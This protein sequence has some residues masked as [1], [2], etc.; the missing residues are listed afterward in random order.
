MKIFASFSVSVLL[1]FLPIIS[2]SQITFDLKPVELSELPGIQSF[3]YAQ[4]DGK[5]LIL[6]GRTDGLHKRRPFEAFLPSGNNGRIYVVDIESKEVWSK[7]LFELPVTLQEQLQSTNMEF[8]QKGDE[9][10]II[11]GYAFSNTAGDHITFPFLAV[12]DVPGVISDIISDNSI[13]DNFKQLRDER[14]A[15]TGGNLEV[16]DDRFYLVGGQRFDGAYN[17]MGP[18]HGPGFSQEY[19]NAIRSFTVEENGSQL[20]IK[21]YESLYDETNL[22]RRDYNL[23]PQIY[24]DG[25]Q[26]FTIFSGVFQHE[27]DLPF[28]NTV[29]ITSNGYAVNNDFSQYLSHYHSAHVP[30]FSE[31]ENKMTTVFFGGISQYFLDAQNILTKDDEVPFV[32][33]ISSITRESDG[34][35]TE[36]KIGEMPGLLGAS[37]EFVLNPSI[38]ANHSGIILLDEL[39]LDETILIGHIVGGIESR[40]ANSFF[41]NSTGLTKA[42]PTI[43]EV[44]LKK[45]NAS[46]VKVVGTKNDLK[47]LPFP[48][49]ADDT[50]I[51]KFS[52]PTPGIVY[53]LLQN[54]AGEIVDSRFSD[55]S[56]PDTYKI[57][58]ETS[59]FPSGIYTVSISSEIGIRSKTILIQH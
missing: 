27:I 3:V 28:L 58:W 14:M 19:T 59:L 2:F 52:T 1:L 40:V 31:S 6:G 15:V 9:L 45:D 35:M 48:N 49:P 30:L 37:A 25:E 50:L 36:V 16:L 26:G 12:V 17:P 11:G 32:K 42:S 7:S 24:P 44:Y 18:N 34:T 43:F 8:V 51:L 21:N 5:W 10:F 56:E 55:I 23:I 46:S 39:P 13:A 41:S 54:A 20:S 22:H 33:T 47:L 4:D 53:F 29:D 57:E 38:A